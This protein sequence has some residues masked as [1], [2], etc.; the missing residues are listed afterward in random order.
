MQIYCYLPSSLSEK[1]SKFYS[2]K[3]EQFKYLI[4]KIS[5][6]KFINT[7]KNQNKILIDVKIE[8]NIQEKTAYLQTD[9]STE[10]L[11]SKSII[12]NLNSVGFSMI[13]YAK[14]DSFTINEPNTRIFHFK[15][16][17]N[18]LII[19]NGFDIAHK[20][21]TKYSDF[22]DEVYSLY[23]ISNE[24]K[25]HSIDDII[26]YKDKN[27]IKKFNILFNILF[28]AN[29]NEYLDELLN[30]QFYLNALCIE[31]IKNNEFNTTE[32]KLYEKYNYIYKN[33]PNPEVYNLAHIILE[34]FSKILE[35]FSSK[36]TTGTFSIS[37]EDVHL[38]IRWFITKI[39]I[40]DNLLIIYFIDKYNH[41][42]LLGD[43]W[44]DIETELSI[45]IKK[46]ESIKLNH[47]NPYLNINSLTSDTFL[48]ELLS[49]IFKT[50]DKNIFK[51]DENIFKYNIKNLTKNLNG[52][53]V[54]LRSYLEYIEN[55]FKYT[56]TKNT[57]DISSICLSITHLLNFNYTD[58]FRKTYCYL[59]DDNV[60]F[61]H[62]KLS[63]NNLVIGISE[64]LDK[65]YEN[66]E[67]SCIKFKK[68]YQRILK[69]TGAKYDDWINT[70]NFDTI[71]I[72]GHSLD[73]TDKEILATIIDNSKKIII[74]Y[75]STTSYSQQIVN[76]IK[77]LGK[78]KFLKYVS[79]SENKIEFVP[80]INL[81]L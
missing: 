12:S 37:D 34:K 3:I 50:E 6:L 68:Y 67:L 42:K 17:Y 16:S 41:K 48:R 33:D 69:K 58:I 78:Q 22:L 51:Y 9:I 27:I 44:I 20:L 63:E 11:S 71:Y 14:L 40:N 25:I 8:T 79:K 76:L 7:N 77:I 75:H 66:T 52:F 72:Y 61:I 13:N 54:L 30:R 28:K 23:K 35:T 55:N 81:Y 18:L 45:I 65:E 74:Y 39:Y 2:L 60:D 21:K 31:L 26:Q 19:G 47:T 38:I 53:I 59:P 1:E 15:L 64:T 57:E 46:L 56:E 73:P 80:Q 36:N 49:I 43:N 4:N 5:P 70:I 29:I 10:N 24:I 32:K 62:G